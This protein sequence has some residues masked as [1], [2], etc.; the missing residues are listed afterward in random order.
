MKI[1]N[2]ALPGIILFLTLL[3]TSFFTHAQ[4]IYPEAGFVFDDAEVPR[5]DLHIST[6]NLQSLYADPESNMEYYATFTFTRAD[7]TEGPIDVALRFRG[8]T[9]RNKQKK[10]FRISFNS[11]DSNDNYHGIE[12]MD[13]NADVNDPSLVRSKLTWELFRYLGLSSSRSN[14]VLLYINNAF[15]GVYLNTEHIDERYTKSRF[16]NNDGNLFRNLWPADLSYLGSSQDDYKYAYDGRRVYALRTNEKWD[17]YEDLATLIT[18]LN[19]YSGAE[20][21]AELERVINVQSYLKAVAVDV[22]SGNW[23]GYTGDKNNYYLYR[24]QVTGRFEY[25]PY[26]LENSFGI[27]FREV[28]WS[29]QSIYSWNLD[30]RPL[31][32][33]VLGVEEYKAQYT[34]YI[35]Q[36]AAY[37]A[38]T[39]LGNE[40]TRWSQQIRD[41]VAM[42][43]FY[44]KDWGFT[45]SDFDGSMNSGWGGHVDQGVL[46]FI[47]ARNASALAEAEDS[48]AL[49]LFSH[50][51]VKPRSDRIDVDWSVEDD[52]TGFTTTLHYRIDGGAWATL[53]KDIPTETD[54]VSGVSS[55]RDTISS[56]GDT[57]KVELYFTV[58]DQGGQENRFPDTTLIIN[59][60]LVSGPLYINEFNASNRSIKKDEFGEYDDWAEIYNA[61][62]EP[63]WL[64]D[65]YLSDNMGSPGKYRF[66]EQYIQA[67]G[68]YLV[69][70]DDQEEQGVNHA[71]FKISK[72]GEELRL[73]LRPSTGFQIVD[74]VTFGLQEAD[75]SMGRRVDGGLEWILFPS[76]TPDYSN[77]LTDVPVNPDLLEPLSIYPNP[78]SEGLFYFSK[79][80]SGSIYNMMGQQVMELEDAEYASIPHLGAGLYIFRSREGETVQFI[81]SR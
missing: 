72:E 33:K 71:T 11:F 62:E 77:L 79:Q 53:L 57:T 29:T 27:D 47:T 61:S 4:V 10:S 36:L 43:T 1:I 38:S 15:Y 30:L 65:Y 45:I 40:L 12:K 14:H 31:Y 51:R 21:K 8:D 32:E 44:T 56:L 75:I 7:S 60:P 66:P 2:S 37:T 50:V 9:I 5:I 54:P 19:Q 70:L 74:S 13:L 63:V 39:E 23:D 76:P 59:Y 42:D 52:E 26:N 55:Y 78:V 17:D 34:M 68:F 67:G 20:L 22:M 6:S 25:I 69:W 80:V 73:S 41:A 46:E 24:D 81:V 48:D 16:D 3:S 58:S 49:P 28:D 35:N 64:A 18:H